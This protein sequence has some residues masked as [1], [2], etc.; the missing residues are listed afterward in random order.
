MRSE[1]EATLYPGVGLVEACKVSVGRGTG[2]P[3]ELVGAPYIEDIRLASALNGEGIAGV[4]FVAA[5]FTPSDSV[6]KNESCGG[7]WILLTDRKKCPVV[8]I[9]IALAEILN[10]WYPEQFALTNMSR[11]LGDEATLEAIAA[12]K[13]LNEI[14]AMWEKGLSEY[15]ARREKYL[16]YGE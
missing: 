2:T 11:L 14:R 8:D 16:L 10:R 4:R 1:T 6:F 7:V 13:P 12:D 3:F 15:K 5:R 9:G